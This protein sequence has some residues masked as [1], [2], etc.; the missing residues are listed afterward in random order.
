M[1][2]IYKL[3]IVEDDEDMAEAMRKLLEKWRFNVSVCKDFEKII[4]SYNAIEPHI[5]LMDINLPVCDGFYWCNKIR[6][7]SSSPIV[8]VSSRDSNMDI[9]MAINNGADD[10]IQKPFDSKVLVAKLQAIV[11]RTYEYKAIDNQIL[12]CDKLI[13]NINEMTVHYEENSSELTK[14]EFLILKILM[15]N[16]GKVVERAT[17]MKELWDE[18]I[19]V[20]E[21]ALSVNVNRLRKKLENM[22]VNDVINTKKG[23]GYIIL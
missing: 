22:G 1:S 3:F 13:V 4:E 9:V 15:K 14:N 12:Q 21:N 18:E 10:Y 16:Q 11:R 20:N 17:L 5:T 6:E 23:M 19:Y 2:N 7:T 8:F